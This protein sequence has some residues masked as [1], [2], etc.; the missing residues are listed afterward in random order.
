M[1]INGKL[2]FSVEN[3]IKLLSTITSTYNLWEDNIP[4]DELDD[5]WNNYKINNSFLSKRE[6]I[7]NLKNYIKNLIDYIKKNTEVKNSIDEDNK[8]KHY[9]NFYIEANVYLEKFI[10]K[11]QKELDSLQKTKAQEVKSVEYK[12][13]EIAED[14]LILKNNSF[15]K[16]G[17]I[18]LI[19]K[20]NIIKLNFTKLNFTEIISIMYFIFKMDCLK[21]NNGIKHLD[22]TGKL[23]NPHF[24]TEKSLN[25]FILDHCAS[26]GND[27]KKGTVYELIKRIKDDYQIL[28]PEQNKEENIVNLKN[29]IKTENQITKLKNNSNFTYKIQFGIEKKFK[30]LLSDKKYYFESELSQYLESNNLIE[31]LNLI[32]KQF[33]IV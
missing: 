29:N 16:Q 21:I 3:R 26:N 1:S 18:E 23:K 4:L 5:S 7:S 9:S 19:E 2:N 32:N 12:L 27:F 8:N 15:I 24:N 20:D 31:L 33:N 10:L 30:Q 22:K 6:R 11:L 25:K 13:V 14:N 17:L 28:N